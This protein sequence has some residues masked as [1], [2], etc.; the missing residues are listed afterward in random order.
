MLTLVVN[1][2]YASIYVDGTVMVQPL[3]T[4]LD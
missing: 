2:G 4:T 3:G 1:N